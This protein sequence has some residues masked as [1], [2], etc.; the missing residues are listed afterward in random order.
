MIKKAILMIF[1]IFLILPCHAQEWEDPLK[2]YPLSAGEEL[3]FDID[4]FFLK[5][6]AIGKSNIELVD[7]EKL[8]YKATVEA[9]IINFFLHRRNIYESVMQFS[10][11]EKTVEINLDLDNLMN[12]NHAIPAL[13]VSVVDQGVGIP[14]N[15]LSSVFDKFT[16]SSKTK[17][18]AGGTGLGL[19][20][21]REI[22]EAHN[23]KIWAEN[24]PDGG[25]TFSFVLPYTQETA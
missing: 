3:N 12:G 21:C 20:I 23:G 2:D 4:V 6:V 13:K 18:G 1:T 15:E 10:P 5:N 22:I 17:T 8:I 24:N 19:S 16:Q 25:A 9:K 14:D 7:A 11:E